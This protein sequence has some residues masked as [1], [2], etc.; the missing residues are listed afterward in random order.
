MKRTKVIPN[1]S[2]TTAGMSIETSNQKE[3]AKSPGPS[4]Y[5]P[6]SAVVLS[7]SPSATIGNTI[8]GIGER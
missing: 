6:K 7:K 1:F 3:R 4:C 5:R 8:R 2:F